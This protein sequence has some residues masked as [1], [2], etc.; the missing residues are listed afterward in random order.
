[1]T[2]STRLAAQ[3]AHPRGFVGRL[4]GKAMDVANERPMQL[5][6]SAL[7][8]APGE[9]I[10]D[11]GCGTGAALSTIAGAASCE[12]YGVDIS[13][14]MIA[15]ARR[16]LG[17]KATLLHGKIDEM[18]AAWCGFDAVLA[19]NV[20]YFA[21]T[22]G[23]MVDAVRRSL[24]PGGRLVAYVSDRQAMERWAF[25]RAGFHRL[26]DRAELETALAQGGFA[27]QSISIKDHR[28]APGIRGLVAYA[29]R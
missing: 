3:L 1:M 10:L 12:L 20:L 4:L 11:F 25:A 8:A 15:A 6:I 27:R 28:V 29:E 24:R 7:G 18:P 17:R 5:A 19:L 2:L 13:A 23:R 26:F 22:E 21:D 9:R 14:T 16:R